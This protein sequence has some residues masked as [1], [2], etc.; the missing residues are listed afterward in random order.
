MIKNQLQKLIDAGARISLSD[1]LSLAFQAGQSHAIDSSASDFFKIHA[2][3]N[4][5]VYGLMLLVESEP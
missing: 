2:G 1:A 3:E 5:V 4:D